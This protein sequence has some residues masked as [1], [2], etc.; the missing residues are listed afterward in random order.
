MMIK[1]KISILLFIAVALFNLSP[2]FSQKKADMITTTWAQ[3][4]IVAD[5]LLDDWQDTL[6]LYNETTKL[7]YSLSNDDKNIYL[8]LKSGSRE[9]LS[10]ILI[11]G[12]SFSANIE[13]IKKESPTVTFP[14]LDR[15]RGKNTNPT[16][17]PE[18]EERQKMTLARIKDIKVSGFKEIVNGGISLQNTYGIKAAAAFDTHNNLVQ[19]IVIPLSLLNIQPGSTDVITY[20]IKVNGIQ[21]PQT[22]MNRQ[23]NDPYGRGYGRGYGGGYGYPQGGMYGNQSSRPQVNKMFTPTEFYIKSALATRQ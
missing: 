8:A 10:R 13:N 14:V 20:R 6:T 18:M 5:G 23:N 16:E 19:E 3:K 9:E 1:I 11:N 22:A 7:R 15:T 21:V 4:S 12:I 2:A 17:E